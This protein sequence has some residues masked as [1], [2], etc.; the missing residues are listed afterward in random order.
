M[1]EIRVFEFPA[2]CQSIRVT[3]RNGDP[4]FLRNDVC[5]MLGHKN[6]SQ[7]VATHCKPDGVQNL[8][9]IDSLGRKQLAT[10]IN[11]ANFNRLVMRSNVKHALEVQD[12]ICEDVLPSIRKTGGYSAKADPSPN[13]SPAFFEPNRYV[14]EAIADP[15]KR[16]EYALHM[17]GIGL[18]ARANPGV[19]PVN[20][21]AQ[22]YRTHAIAANRKDV[23]ELYAPKVATIVSENSKEYTA[24]ALGRKLADSLGGKYSGMVVNQMLAGLGIIGKND[25]NEWQVTTY[26]SEYAVKKNQPATH[27]GKPVAVTYYDQRVFEMLK[28]QL[29]VD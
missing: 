28:S 2:T 17:L 21:E 14:M 12:W 10:I 6:P 25:L 1:S 7:A 27:S 19:D 11:E 24:T 22:I 9:V 23:F 18:V 8:E 3:D 13:P 5:E 29:E 15:D 20:L 4:W 26:G 16:A